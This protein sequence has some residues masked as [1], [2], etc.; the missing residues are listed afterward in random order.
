MSETWAATGQG[1]SSRR[2]VVASSLRATLTATALVCLY[3]LVPV[4]GEFDVSAGVMLAAGLL[5]LAALLTHQIR[6]ITQATSPGLRAVEVL[7]T[8]LPLFLVLFSLAYLVLGQHDEAAFS[9][10]LSQ[11]DALYFTL[12]IFATVGFGDIT[13]VSATARAT[14]TAQIALDLVL[15]GLGLRVILGAVEVGRSRRVRTD[16]NHEAEPPRQASG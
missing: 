3:F 13:A 6:S 9:E 8:T 11:L 10:P 2:A 12:T 5:A 4:T 16:E 15:L 14:V 7:A 1:L